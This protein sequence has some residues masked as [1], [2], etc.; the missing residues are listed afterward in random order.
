MHSGCTSTGRSNPPLGWLPLTE[1]SPSDKSAVTSFIQCCTTYQY[2][3][4]LLTVTDCIQYSLSVL[5]STVHYRVCMTDP[6]HVARGNT[7]PYSRH[8]VEGSVQWEDQQT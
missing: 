6:C 4:H 8:C 5:Y 2:R 3:H 1:M 7:G